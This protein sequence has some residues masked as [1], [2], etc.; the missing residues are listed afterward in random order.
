[1]KNLVCVLGER[2]FI[3]SALTAKLKTKYEVTHYPSEK[4]KI[5][6]DFASPTH[7]GFET[8]IGYNFSTIINRMSYL[9]KFCVDN[10]IKYVYPSSALVYEL[11][12][13]FKAF[14]EITEK[15]QEVFPVNALALRIFPIYG[16]GETRTAIY[17]FCRDIKSGK[18]QIR[19][20]IYISDVIDNIIRFSK[21]KSGTIDIGPGK[22]HA[23]NQVVNIIN[24]IA[25]TNLKPIYVKSPSVYS[26]GIFCKNPVKCRISLENGIKKV[27]ESL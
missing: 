19:D 26:N 11:D 18:R 2:G 17:Q 14:K 6:Y 27:Y 7:E 21:T 10:N 1:M 23:L 12:R 4:C 3:G 20:F 13:P 5:I 16:I 8:N 15:M 9:M 24:K 22:P 25:N